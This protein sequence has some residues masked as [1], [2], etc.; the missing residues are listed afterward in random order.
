[1]LIKCVLVQV[2]NSCIY[3]GVEEM[4]RLRNVRVQL[5]YLRDYL[6]TCREPIIE[7]FKKFIWPRDYMYEH[8]H[9]YSIA[10]SGRRW[11]QQKQ[12]QQQHTNHILIYV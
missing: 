8:I 6:F 9:Q 2:L 12:Q 4:Q 10:V 3:K 1:M 7:Q 5:N 11:Q